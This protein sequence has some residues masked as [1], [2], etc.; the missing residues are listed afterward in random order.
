[1]T[2]H[3]PL[4][5]INLFLYK[6][7]YIYNKIKLLFDTLKKDF[8]IKNPKI[9]FMGINPHAGENGKIGNEEIFIKKIIKK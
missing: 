5:K 3:I 9:A 1:M 4:K 2:T 8:D 7:N 6:K